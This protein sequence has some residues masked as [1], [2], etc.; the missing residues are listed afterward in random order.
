MTAS[1]MLSAIIEGPLLAT[2][3]AED[4][5]TARELAV[6]Y[7][8]RRG[9]SAMAATVSGAGDDGFRATARFLRMERHL[10][11]TPTLVSEGPYKPYRRADHFNDLIAECHSGPVQFSSVFWRA[12]SDREQRLAWAHPVSGVELSQHVHDSP[13]SALR[14]ARR[15][16]SLSEDKGPLNVTLMLSEEAFW[17]FGEDHSSDPAYRGLSVGRDP[18]GRVC[19]VAAKEMV[20]DGRRVRIQMTHEIFAEGPGA[21]DADPV[22]VANAWVTRRPERGFG[23]SGMQFSEADVILVHRWEVARPWTE[24]QG[25]LR[26]KPPTRSAEAAFGS[27]A[28]DHASSRWCSNSHEAWLCCDD[29]FDGAVVRIPMHRVPPDHEAHTPPAPG[30]DYRHERNFWLAVDD[31]PADDLDFDQLAARDG[32]ASMDPGD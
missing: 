7:H 24:E 4:W 32:V 28:C 26:G 14:A 15:L 2:L 29:C 19:V 18:S 30:I 3:D 23:P 8:E 1:Y 25:A 31:L 13:E 27:G 16:L 6:E 21:K 11:Q 17:S 10:H 9:D 20:I 12:R 22:R 5:A